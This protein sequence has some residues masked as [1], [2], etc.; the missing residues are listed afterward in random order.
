[1]A[2]CFPSVS[3]A[4]ID[5]LGSVRPLLCHRRAPRR[6]EG[7]NTPQAVLRQNNQE[8]SNSAIQTVAGGFL[9]VSWA[10]L[11]GLGV[12]EMT[13][14]RYKPFFNFWFHAIF[15][16]CVGPSSQYFVFCT[17]F[18]PC[19]PNSWMSQRVSESAIEQ[20]RGN[21]FHWA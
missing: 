6:F 11:E 15:F 7:E 5:G 4:L 2:G 14:L 16:L 19:I 10:L 1:M 13:R 17:V 20:T 21:R 9:H 12:P 3:G 18:S 8:K